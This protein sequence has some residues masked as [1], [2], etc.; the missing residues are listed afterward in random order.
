MGD[1]FPEEPHYVVRWEGSHSEQY[2]VIAR[3]QFFSELRDKFTTNQSIQLGDGYFVSKDI[4]R[5]EDLQYLE[6]LAKKEAFPLNVTEYIMSR[7]QDEYGVLIQCTTE[8]NQEQEVDV[9]MHLEG[10]FEI[11]EQDTEDDMPREEWDSTEY[12]EGHLYSESIHEYEGEVEEI[13][14]VVSYTETENE[15]NR[16]LSNFG[17]E[18]SSTVHSF[19]G[20]AIDLSIE[21]Y[22]EFMQALWRREAQEGRKSTSLESLGNR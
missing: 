18:W 10:E 11:L 17:R 6:Q 12:D 2:S 15:V 5:I 7:L 8:G 22:Y 19:N 4:K 9:N 20:K 1:E 14:H 16:A 13:D 3:D 21:K